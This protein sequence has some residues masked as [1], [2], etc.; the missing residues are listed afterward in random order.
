[1]LSAP[2]NAPPLFGADASGARVQTTLNFWQQT[3]QR[4]PRRVPVGWNGAPCG[5]TR[6]AT[7]SFPC[8]GPCGRMCEAGTLAQPF[9]DAALTASTHREQQRKWQRMCSACY[10]RE[11]AKALWAKGRRCARAYGVLAR[12]LL[13]ALARATERVYAPGGIGFVQ[14]RDEFEASEKRARLM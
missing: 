13:Q 9:F 11:R 6:S 1:M 8:I 4:Q 5:P 2:Q 7:H 10:V 14:A 12:G 3:Q